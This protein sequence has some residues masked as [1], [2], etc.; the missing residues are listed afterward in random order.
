MTQDYLPIKISGHVH[1]QYTDGDK[2]V[3]LD[4]HNDIHPQNMARVIARSLAN[5]NNFFIHRMA[6]GNGGT[7]TDAAFQISYRPPNT[8]VA[9]DAN[10]FGSRLYN[11]TY[12]EI[13]DDSNVL[14]GT[15]QGSA[16]ANVG[17]RIGGGSVEGSDPASVEHVSGSGVRSNELG[18]I[19]QVS[20][21]VVLNPNEPNGQFLTD[22]QAPTENTETDF[23]FDEIGLYTSGSDA[24]DT[25]G[26]QSLDVGNRLSTDD[27][28][29]LA[30][31]QYSFNITVDGGSI[32]IITFTTPAIGGSGA[33]GEILYGDVV[34]AIMTGDVA[35][36]N[37][38]GDNFAGIP[39]MNGASISITDYSSSFTAIPTGTQTFGNILFQSDNT[40]VGSN[41]SVISGGGGGLPLFEALNA[42]TGAV[43]GSPIDGSFAGIQ[44]DPVNN[45]NERERLLTHLTFS[46]VLK[47][48][49]RTISINYTLTISVASS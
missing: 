16:G 11:E 40:G 39:I 22:N 47:S 18:V 37:N 8:G 15:D 5:E 20:I 9:P 41:I 19:S 3:L 25:A 38:T 29:L 44:N 2:E 43:I 21:S 36:N 33:S 32:Q 27:S 4:E 17:Q 10:T 7:E 28:T 42:P 34:Q 13:V 24:L 45:A 6:F 12:S 1:A 31:T 30:N 23:T 46:P 14:I 35:W 49:N 26:T 48:A